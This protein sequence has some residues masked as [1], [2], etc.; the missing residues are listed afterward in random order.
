METNELQLFTNELR[1]LVALAEPFR[2][3]IPL[4]IFDSEK[5]RFTRDSTPEWRAALTR[6]HDLMHNA[7]KAVLPTGACTINLP[8]ITMHD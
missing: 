4:V 7:S 8:L 6:K 5:L 1:R 3:P 2:V